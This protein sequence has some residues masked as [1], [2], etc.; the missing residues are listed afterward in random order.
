MNK[1]NTSK[2]Q[3][4]NQL[5]LKQSLSTVMDAKLTEMKNDSHSKKGIFDMNVFLYRLNFIFKCLGIK[6]SKCIRYK[7]QTI[8]VL[9]FLYGQF[10]KILLYF[11]T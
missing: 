3:L 10:N 5:K 7:I 1:D 4:E 2:N 8:I 6:H 9:G 11:L